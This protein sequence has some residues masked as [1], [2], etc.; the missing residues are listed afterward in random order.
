MSL[1]IHVWTSP[2]MNSL[3][4]RFCRKVQQRVVHLTASTDTRCTSGCHPSSRKNGRNSSTRQQS[5]LAAI[6]FMCGDW[7]NS[8]Y[9]DIWANC[10]KAAVVLG[11]F[12]VVAVSSRYKIEGNSSPLTRLSSCSRWKNS[13][14]ITTKRAPMMET[15]THQIRHFKLIRILF[16]REFVNSDVFFS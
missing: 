1:S 4:D 9:G 10:S 7:K 5:A 6:S 12:E 2:A 16:K 14:R 3:N 11:T 15:F 8:G 13:D